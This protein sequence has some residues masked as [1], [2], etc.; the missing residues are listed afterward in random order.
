MWIRP[1]VDILAIYAHDSRSWW[2]IP[3]NAVPAGT[4]RVCEH[5]KQGTWHEAWSLFDAPLAA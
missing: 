1:H 5:G 4:I 3:R 2:F